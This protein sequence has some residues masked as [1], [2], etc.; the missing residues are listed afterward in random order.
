MSLHYTKSH[1]QHAK[2]DAKIVYYDIV[3]VKLGNYL[4]NR[5][6]KLHPWESSMSRKGINILRK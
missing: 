2:G 5:N 3:Y 6:D 4:Q 1:S